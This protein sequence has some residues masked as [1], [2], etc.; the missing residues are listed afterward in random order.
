[1]VA[2][3]ERADGALV[4]VRLKPRAGTDRIDGERAGALEVRVKAAPV[5]GRANEALLRLLAKR[6]RRPRSTL[7]LVRGRRGRNK[8]VL[9]RGMSAHEVELEFGRDG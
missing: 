6:L 3:G 5:E 8:Q 1:M 9:V 4:S 7:E 2:V